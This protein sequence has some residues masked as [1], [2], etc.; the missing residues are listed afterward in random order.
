MGTNTLDP[1]IGRALLP[2]EGVYLDGNGYLRR[3]G[4]QESVHRFT[5]FQ[6]HPHANKRHHI[7][8]I[9]GRKRD[10]RI[11]N[12]IDLRAG[13]HQ[14][15]HDTFT[16]Q[17]LPTREEI[18]LWIKSQYR[19]IPTRLKDKTRKQKKEKKVRKLKTQR[20]ERNLNKKVKF[21]FQKGHKKIHY[22]P[23]MIDKPFKAK[24]LV[25]KGGVKP[26]KAV[27]SP[28]EKAP[29]FKGE[30]LRCF[31]RSRRKKKKKRNRQEII[32]PEPARLGMWDDEFLNQRW[33]RFK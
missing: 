8:H 2:L 33:A 19:Q 32:E 25:R 12:L 22:A 4:D 7:H 16:M 27:L 6:A 3:R 31:D 24:V 18:L 14:R 1:S 13:I 26:E 17:Y 5:Y 20:F 29:V 30:L 28:S 21:F 11:E 9:N 10:N 23:A 15:L